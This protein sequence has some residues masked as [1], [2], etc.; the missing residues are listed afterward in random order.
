MAF[1]RV[2]LEHITQIKSALGISGVQVC[3]NSWKCDADYDKGLQGSQIDLLIVRK[4]QIIN[5]CEMKYSESDYVPDL[6]F[7]KAMRRKMSDLKKSTGTKYSIHSTLIT[8]YE[9]K[10]TPYSGDIQSVVTGDDLFQ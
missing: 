7:D 6:A 2:C 5:V 3:V 4:D 9:V 10:E 8:N 1:E